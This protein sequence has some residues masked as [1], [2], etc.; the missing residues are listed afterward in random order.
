MKKKKKERK[1]RKI[2]D[3]APIFAYNKISIK[4]IIIPMNPLRLIFCFSKYTIHDP[5]EAVALMNW[6]A[7]AIYYVDNGTLWPERSRSG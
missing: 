3:E 2:K 6:I 4:C 7:I 5:S 1:E